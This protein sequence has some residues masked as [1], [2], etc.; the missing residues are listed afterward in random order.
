MRCN[1][2]IILKNAETTSYAEY[3]AAHCSVGIIRTLAGASSGIASSIVTCPLDVVKTRLQAQGGFRHKSI[4][5]NIPFASRGLLGVGHAVWHEKG[6]K[7]MYQG[8]GPTLLGH[9]PRWAIFFS[10][11]HRSREIFHA[12]LES[13]WVSS[14]M[15]SATAGTCSI[16]ATIPIQF[17]KT[18][19]MSQTN[20]SSQTYAMPKWQYKS[21]FDA[22]QQI[23]RN[24]GILAFYSGLTPALLGLSQLAIQFPLYETL[25]R[26]L[27]GSGLGEIKDCQNKTSGIIA[28]GFLSK[29]VSTS[30]AYPH[31][32]IR[33]RLQTQQILKSSTP[34]YQRYTG[35]VQTARTIWLEEGWHALYAG[36]G[37]N[38]MRAVPASIATML[39]YEN[40]L[41]KLTE[42]KANGE[43][44]LGW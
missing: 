16:V 35:I 39:V 19:L 32:V 22:A 34:L 7:G 31:E 28:A 36:F 1:H 5:T 8:L 11:Y 14:L 43:R 25:K 6:L 27:T 38:L 29:I 23:Y 12:Y 40:M 24:E 17:I 9:V 21:A 42:L 4:S 18:R 10:T 13:Q 2:Q 20:T 41:S 3:V 33:T 44:K 30:L 26:G 15:A 37:T